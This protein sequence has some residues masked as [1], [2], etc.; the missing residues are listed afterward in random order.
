MSR[1]IVLVTGGS[2]GIGLEIVRAFARMGDK[3]WFNDLREE[4]VRETE[5]ALLGEGLEVAGRACDVTDFAGVGALVE[6]IVAADGALDVLVN[7]AGITRD[8]LMMRM[9]EEQWDLVLQ[10]NLKGCFNTI[11]HAVK[12]MMKKREGRIVNIA[13]VVG[14]M[15]NAGQA[16]Y[17]AAKAGVIGLTK[18]MARELAGRNVLVNAVAPGYIETEMT[19]HLPQAAKDELSR[20]IPLGRHGQPADVAAVVLFLAGP[21]SSYITGQVLQ[22]DGGMHM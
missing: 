16:N 20:Q 21:A 14:V 1:R 4:Q 2:R 22:V 6:E 12:P 8:A 3:V 17:A 19:A 11:R 7:N 18:T 15:G 5:A 9:A 10:T 13:S